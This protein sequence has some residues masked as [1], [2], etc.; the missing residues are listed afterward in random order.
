MAPVVQCRD[1]GFDC[2]GVI[3]AD[4]EQEALA[5]AAEHAHGLT[6]INDEVVQVV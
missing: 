3:R 1:V 4:S 6:Q 5:Q 2:H